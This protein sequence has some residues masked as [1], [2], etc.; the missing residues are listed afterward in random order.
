[1][2]TRTQ[3]I[4]ALRG[5]ADRLEAGC[6]LDGTE[7]KPIEYISVSPE[8]FE[9]HDQKCAQETAESWLE[10]QDTDDIWHEAIDRVSWGVYVSVEE[11]VEISKVEV[12]GK[13]YD[14]EVEY[15]LQAV[16]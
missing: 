10:W 12:E 3:I 6:S 4:R 15:E 8:D 9:W 14:E 16:I 2:E 5:L 11:A 7:D 13:P 1:M